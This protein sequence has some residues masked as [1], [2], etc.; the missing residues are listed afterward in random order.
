MS[1][2]L[3]TGGVPRNWGRA[4]I[5]PVPKAPGL[6][7]VKD[8]RP[9]CLQNV[10][11]KWLTATLLIMVQDALNQVAPPQQ[12]GFLKG[13]FMIDHLVSARDLWV[14]NKEGTYVALD[15]SKAYDTVSDFFAES[16]F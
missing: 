16:V 2:F 5:R 9:I 3:A 8:Q 12:K 4:A 10:R 11:T 13:R 1:T 15:Y 14:S 7:S 6:V